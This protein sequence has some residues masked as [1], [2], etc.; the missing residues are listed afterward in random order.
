[1]LIIDEISFA[2]GS[3]LV[4][5]HNQL[6]ALK[7]ARSKKYGGLNIVFAG[8]FR[9]LKPVGEKSLYEDTALAHWHDWVNC[10]IELCGNHRFGDDPKYG[11]VC[12]RFRDGEPTDEDFDYMNERVLNVELPDKIWMNPGGPTIAEV[13][14]DTAYAVPTN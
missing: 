14:S 9:Q 7:E 13:P 2:K 3:A 12:K 8:D 10:F 5:L 6:S 11:E 4:T 1:M